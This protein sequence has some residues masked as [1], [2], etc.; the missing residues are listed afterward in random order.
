ME[1]KSISREAAIELFGEREVYSAEVYALSR[2]TKRSTDRLYHAKRRNQSD[3]G[4]WM[5]WSFTPTA[6]MIDRANWID[7]QN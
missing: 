5:N 1:F 7:T 6:E 2:E 3:R 4:L